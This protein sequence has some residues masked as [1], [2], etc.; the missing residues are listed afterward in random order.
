MTP[1][2]LYQ[3]NNQRLMKMDTW[4]LNLQLVLS[5]LHLLF[6]HQI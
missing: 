5:L 6:H 1:T 4:I 3:L 2:A